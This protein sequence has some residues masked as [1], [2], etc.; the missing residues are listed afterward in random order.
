MALPVNLFVELDDA[1]DVAGD[2]LAPDRMRHFALHWATKRL[3]YLGI[4]LDGYSIY[5]H[6]F[7]LRTRFLHYDMLEEWKDRYCRLTWLYWTFLH[8]G[9]SA[10]VFPH[11][12][13]QISG[14]GF[15]VGD[16]IDRVLR[17]AENTGPNCGAIRFQALR[18]VCRKLGAIRLPLNQA[19]PRKNFHQKPPRAWSRYQFFGDTFPCLAH[20]LSDPDTPESWKIRCQR[21]RRLGVALIFQA[22]TLGEPSTKES[23]PLALSRRTHH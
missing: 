2:H 1:L 4:L 18:W 8:Q 13:A 6:S 23:T 10:F 12:T 20:R 14:D 19:A 5:D 16:K 22:V 11:N 15:F 7:D 9:I 3:E 21:A 17:F